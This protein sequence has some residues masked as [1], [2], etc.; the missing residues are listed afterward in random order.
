M[1]ASSIAVLLPLL[2]FGTLFLSCWSRPA[3]WRTSFLTAALAW[4]TLLTVITEALSIF[5]LLTQAWVAGAW[6]LISLVLCLRLYRS[7]RQSAVENGR[8]QTERL[9]QPLQSLL[10]ATGLLTASVGLIAL[11]APPNNWDSMAYHMPRV[12]HW[13]E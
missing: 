6:A 11:V 10:Y 1:V 2:A 7:R 9:A 12:V 5:R 4:G 13:I 8:G 3:C